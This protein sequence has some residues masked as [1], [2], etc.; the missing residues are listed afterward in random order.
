MKGKIRG[1]SLA[2]SLSNSFL[3]NKIHIPNEK[4]FIKSALKFRLRSYVGIDE[5]YEVDRTYQKL[6]T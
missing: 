4:L 1:I 5:M 2:N 3:Y 6:Y